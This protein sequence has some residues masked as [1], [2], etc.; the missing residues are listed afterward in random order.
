M[1]SVKFRNILHYKKL[2]ADLTELPDIPNF[3]VVYFDAFCAQTNKHQ[4]G[5]KKFSHMCLRIPI[6]EEFLPRIVQKVMC[7]ECCSRWGFLLNEPTDPIGKREML[8]ATNITHE[9][10]L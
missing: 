10:A 6:L 1:N 2:H 3:D 5:R 4:C 7:A 9:L 8:R